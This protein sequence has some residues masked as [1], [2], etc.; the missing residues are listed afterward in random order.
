VSF[1]LLLRALS[2]SSSFSFFSLSKNKEKPSY[3]PGDDAVEARALVR[4]RLAPRG[5]D[6][7][8]ARAQ[9]AEV[10]DRLR[11]GLAVEAHD[12]AAGGLAAD[13]DVEEDLRVVWFL[14]WWWREVVGRG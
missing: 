13:V 12:D 3:S 10:L 7:L 14:R 2:S 6:A 8:L 4:E 9:G 5:A 11:D 1:L